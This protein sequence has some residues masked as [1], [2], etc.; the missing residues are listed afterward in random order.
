MALSFDTFVSCGRKLQ[1]GDVTHM[2]YIDQMQSCKLVFGSP[3][4]IHFMSYFWAITCASWS[5]F[6]LSVLNLSFPPSLSGPKKPSAPDMFTESDVMFEA[7]I[8]VSLTGASLPSTD[9]QPCLYLWS[10][11]C[12]SGVNMQA[13]LL[14]DLSV[15]VVHYASV[16]ECLVMLVYTECQDESSR[17]WGEGLQREPQPPGQL[18]RRRGL[19]P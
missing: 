5:M 6:P 3:V 10:L 13:H 19:L 9:L 17:C 2:T 14:S 1:C 15:A 18:D 11:E 12:Y 4:V 7:A 16:V 8:D